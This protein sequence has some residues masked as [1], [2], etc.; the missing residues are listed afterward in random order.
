MHRAVGVDRLR[1]VTVPGSAR[2][3]LLLWRR[4]AEAAGVD[5]SIAVEAGVRT[6]P[7]LGYASCELLRRI[8]EAFDGD[9]PDDCGRLIRAVVAPDLEARAGTEPRVRLDGPGL[10]VASAWNRRTVEAI[11]AAGVR[12]V[13]D[14]DVDLPTEPPADADAV[15]P[16]TDGELLDAS[17]T[18]R[19][20]LIELGA[21]PASDRPAGLDAAI[22]ELAAMI[23][24]TASVDLTAARK[25]RGRGRG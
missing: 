7:S 6:N 12:V 13:G 11:R 20:S 23:R 25:A 2:D 10:T 17:A 21:T 24:E 16:P 22:H 14:L 19:A 15:P 9:L 1:V 3:P 18:A 4:F 5:A 8:N